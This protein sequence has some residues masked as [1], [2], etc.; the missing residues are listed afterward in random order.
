VSTRE[1]RR[2]ARIARLLE[3][4]QATAETWARAEYE[5][6]V[7]DG[8]VGVVVGHGERQRA[9]AERRFRDVAARLSAAVTP[10]VAAEEAQHRLPLRRR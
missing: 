5:A 8:R 1:E 9:T 2:Q 6:G 4:V 7:M 3:Q 10:P